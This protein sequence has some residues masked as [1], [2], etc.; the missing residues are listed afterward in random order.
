MACAPRAK[1][2]LVKQSKLIV[3]LRQGRLPLCVDCLF[4]AHRVP[5]L[6]QGQQPS[7]LQLTCS[8]SNP[9]KVAVGLIVMMPVDLPPSAF[10]PA[11]GILRGSE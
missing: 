9:V 1:L 3:C 6:H 10:A 2:H 8:P 4:A 5:H 11:A 7:L